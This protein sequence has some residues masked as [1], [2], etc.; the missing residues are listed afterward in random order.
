MSKI[1]QKNNPLSFLQQRINYA[2]KHIVDPTYYV[3]NVPNR[4]DNL[5]A[6]HFDFNQSL[7]YCASQGLPNLINTIIT[8]EKKRYQLDVCYEQAM[9]TN[10][11]M[12]ALSLIFQS[13]RT[14]GKKVLCQSPVFAS[15]SELLINN[16]YDVIYI[17]D[18]LTPKQLE[19]FLGLH[20]DANFIYINTP[21]NPTGKIYSNDYLSVILS[22]IQNTS[23]KLVVDLVYD[24]FVFIEHHDFNPLLL[25]YDWS[26]VF[27]INSV[28]KN[29]GL[30]GLR[31]GWIVSHAD[32]ILKLVKLL[33]DDCVC[34]NPLTQEFAAQAIALGNNELIERVSNGKKIIQEL[35]GNDNK[36]RINNPDGGTQIYARF[37]V[38]DI[39]D[40]ADYM[41]I[42][43]DLV[44]ATTSNYAMA[45]EQSIR[46]PIGC[47]KE[48]ILYCV[49]TLIN[50]LG[51]Y[52]EQLNIGLN[53]QKVYDST[54]LTIDA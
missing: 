17:P 43:Y 9:I 31:V 33:E 20:L 16:H 2:E 18:K 13:L 35:L 1:I 11:G 3:E 10:G 37:P 44:L 42:N 7:N 27:T 51:S 5:N 19:N 30:P 26:K 34:V 4:E 6:L 41:L 22:F 24:D 47:P 32:N 40:F 8:R 38:K 49:S 14:H 52:I 45:D 28:S 53:Q 29:W 36:I 46:M 25:N 54:A 50:G 48:K 23:S 15:V 12:H 39:E 21:N